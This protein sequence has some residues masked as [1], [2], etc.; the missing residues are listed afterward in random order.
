MCAKTYAFIG[1]RIMEGKLYSSP[2]NHPAR[3]INPKEQP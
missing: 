2:P 1:I 3:A